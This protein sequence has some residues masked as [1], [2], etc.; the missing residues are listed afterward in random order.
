DREV[1]VGFG[2]DGAEAHRPG[3]ETADDLARGLDLLERHRRALRDELPGAPQRDEAT[4]GVV[5]GLRVLLVALDVLETDRVLEL[6][7]GRRVPEVAFTLR[8]VVVLPAQVE[9]RR[10]VDDARVGLLVAAP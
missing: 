10:R 4:L 1:L 2:A 5:D 8:A 3:R 6:R 9:H 7:H